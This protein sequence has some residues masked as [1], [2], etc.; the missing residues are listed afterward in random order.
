[1]VVQRNIRII[2]DQPDM[3]DYFC[4][5]Q[6]LMM[7]KAIDLHEK[8][9]RDEHPMFVIFMFA[10]DTSETLQLLFKNHINKVGDTGGLEQVGC[11][12]W[13][14]SGGLEQVG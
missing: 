5:F 9:L 10:R 1:M 11:N 8:M 2:S 14:G 6:I 4:Y 13:V 7:L 3:L 12:I